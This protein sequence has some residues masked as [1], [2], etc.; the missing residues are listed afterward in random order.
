MKIKDLTEGKFY[1]IKFGL[2]TSFHKLGDTEDCVI[3]YY[4]VDKMTYFIIKTPDTYKFY[5]M[6]DLIVNRFAKEV[7]G[8]E[9]IEYFLTK[10]FTIVDKDEFEK[11]KLKMIEKEV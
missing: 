11:M 3:A 9:S 2:L 10:P 4:K 1:D 7:V 6:V 8:K 5:T